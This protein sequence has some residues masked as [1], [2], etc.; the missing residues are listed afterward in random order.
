MK[1]KNW[2]TSRTILLAIVTGIIGVMMA[3]SQ[4]YPDIGIF[5]T[6]VAGLNILLRF[7]TTVPIK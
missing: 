5:V 2:W 1:I 3:F 7:L 4:Q 6:I